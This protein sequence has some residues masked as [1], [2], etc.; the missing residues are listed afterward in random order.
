MASI[1]PENGQ[2]PRSTRQLPPIWPFPAEAGTASPGTSLLL[3]EERR[4]V[5]G[6]LDDLRAFVAVAEAGGFS[7]AAARLGLAKS[8]VSRRV[9]R[10]EASLGARLLARTTRGVSPTEAGAAFQARCV[11][12]LA[13]L[14]EARDEVAGRQ[15]GVV[16]TLRLAVP[17]SFG[18]AHLAP[19]LARFAADHPRLGLDVAYGD[20]MVDLVAERFDAAIRIGV[21][22]DS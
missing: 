18:V 6:E 16:G 10:L 4:P 21:L 12:V 9:A 1:S 7:R 20:R 13:E 3:Q 17:L 22:P 5:D 8:I 2:A 11:R 14:D 19:A 15:G